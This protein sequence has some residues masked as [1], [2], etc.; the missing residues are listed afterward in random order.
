MVVGV[1]GTVG[2]ERLMV[3]AHN[4][5]VTE[6]LLLLGAEVVLLHLCSMKMHVVHDEN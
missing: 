3:V 1:A 6:V 4:Q 5:V 2:T